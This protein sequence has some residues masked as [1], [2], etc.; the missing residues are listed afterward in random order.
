MDTTI[1][2]IK[3]QAALHL[4]TEQNRIDVLKIMSRYSCKFNPHQGGE[5]GRTALHL[6]AIYDFAECANILVSSSHIE[7]P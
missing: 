5:H 7:V 1:Q 6:A 2:N 4:A 3:K